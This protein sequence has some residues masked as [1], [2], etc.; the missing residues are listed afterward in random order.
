MPANLQGEER[1]TLI[2]A[3]F[4]RWYRRRALDALHRAI[5]RLKNKVGV[6]PTRVVVRDQR[7]RWGSC[8]PDGTLR[9]EMTIASEEQIYVPDQSAKLHEE[10]NR[11]SR[12][13]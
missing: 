2:R 3:A 6:R 8:S 12:Y 11:P 5:E 10:G 13:R 7:Q 1:R 9:M 4:A